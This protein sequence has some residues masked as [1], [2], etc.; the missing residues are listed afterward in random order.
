ML[1]FSNFIAMVMEGGMVNDKKA[2][3]KMFKQKKIKFHRFT[4]SPNFHV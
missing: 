2:E 3:S 4:V 1:H